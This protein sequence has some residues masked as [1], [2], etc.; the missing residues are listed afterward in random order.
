MSPKAA[1]YGTWSSPITADVIT[2]GVSIPKSCLISNLFLTFLQSIDLPDVLVD[3]ITSTVYHIES[4]PS[5]AGRS[6]LVHTGSGRD[7]VGKKWDVRTGVQEYGGAP[8]I[9]HSGVAYFSHYV[10]GR[11]YRVKDSGEPEAVTPGEFCTVESIN[12]CV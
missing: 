11:V 3:H 12:L 6:V 4:R 10:D 7:V 1:P 9:V 8:A 2:Q 5:E